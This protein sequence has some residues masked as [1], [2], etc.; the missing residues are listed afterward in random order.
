MFAIFFASDPQHTFTGFA[1]VARIFL[2]VKIGGL[3]A[4]PNYGRGDN[5]FMPC[6]TYVAGLSIPTSRIT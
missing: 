3:I 2:A 5:Y 6:T 4:T 1:E